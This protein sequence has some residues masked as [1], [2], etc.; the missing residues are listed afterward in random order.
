[1]ETSDE[2]LPE[3]F[4]E[5]NRILNFAE[6]HFDDSDEF[7]RWNGRQIRNA[8]QIAFS[9]ANYEYQKSQAADAQKQRALEA[10]D[11]NL[12]VRGS[13]SKRAL[14]RV[15]YL[16]PVL[17]DIHFKQVAEATRKFSQYMQAATNST[18]RDFAQS[19]GYRA[20]DW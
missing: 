3:L 1:Q 11:T 13:A 5:E 18:D 6:Y 17:T 7:E 19:G 4:I 15:R 14:S 10:D 16:G 9:L 8:F 12:K 20:D 2:K